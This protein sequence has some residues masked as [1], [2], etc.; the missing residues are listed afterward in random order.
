MHYG[1]QM[2]YANKLRGDYPNKTPSARQSS[3]F[4]SYTSKG[5]PGQTGLHNYMDDHSYKSSASNTGGA[6]VG[7]GT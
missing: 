5:R 4:G 7:G 2:K 1:D 3:S 6:S